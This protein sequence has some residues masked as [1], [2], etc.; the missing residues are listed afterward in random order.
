M[1]VVYFQSVQICI[2]LIQAQKQ[3]IERR[4]SIVKEKHIITEFNKLTENLKS[5]IKN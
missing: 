4:T 5:S 1:E 2:E 3:L